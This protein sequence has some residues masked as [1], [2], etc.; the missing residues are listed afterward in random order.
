MVA[1]G[2]IYQFGD[3]D[4]C[5]TAANVDGVMSSEA[6]LENPALFSGKVV[7]LDRLALQYLELAEKHPGANDSCLRGHMFKIMFTGLQKH[8]DL[9]ERLVRASGLGNFRQIVL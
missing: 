9:R 7:D 2:G 4:R 6:L 1:N 3:V 5:L 8:T